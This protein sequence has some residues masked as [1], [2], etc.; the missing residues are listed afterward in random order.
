MIKSHIYKIVFEDDKS[1]NEKAQEIF[2]FMGLFK[3]YKHH[4]SLMGLDISL[5]RIPVSVVKKLIIECYKNTNNH[6]DNVTFDDIINDMVEI[7]YD[8]IVTDLFQSLIG[9][10]SET[11][12]QEQKK[13]KLKYLFRQ[14]I[15]CFIPN[16]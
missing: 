6:F 5:Y 9:K 2:D 15:N 8:V 3:K 14:V 7:S 10:V 12:D 4:K 16:L 11:E 13:S 1:V